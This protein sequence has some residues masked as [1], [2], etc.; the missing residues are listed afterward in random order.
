MKKYMLNTTTG[1]ITATIIEINGT[2]L[3]SQNSL[4]VYILDIQKPTNT[5]PK[6]AKTIHISYS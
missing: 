6:Y 2:E 4:T 3:K 5:L 1:L